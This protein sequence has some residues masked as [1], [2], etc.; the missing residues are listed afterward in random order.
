V[1]CRPSVADASLLLAGDVLAD[2]D[3]VDMVWEHETYY[4]VNAKASNGVP[5][6]RTFDKGYRISLRNA[7]S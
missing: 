6:I 1:A 2:G 3:V 5:V 7:V 4:A